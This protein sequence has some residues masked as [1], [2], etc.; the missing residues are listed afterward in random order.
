[1]CSSGQSSN[2]RKG[3]DADLPS[4]SEDVTKYPEIPCKNSQCRTGWN[5]ACT[6][7]NCVKMLNSLLSKELLGLEYRNCISVW[8][9]RFR[10]M[11]GWYPSHWLVFLTEHWKKKK[12]NQ[13]FTMWYLRLISRAAKIRSQHSPSPRVLMK[14]LIAAA[15]PSEEAGPALP[16]S[17]L[18]Q[19]N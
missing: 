4:G 12:R 6:K 5:S 15:A 10:K 17:L 3:S 8:R 14:C 7:C 1:M 16:S 11:G 19:L 18:G 13:N 9:R 2:G